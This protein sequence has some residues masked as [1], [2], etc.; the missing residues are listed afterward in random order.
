MADKHV[1]VRRLDPFCRHPVPA[2]PDENT[3]LADDDDGANEPPTLFVELARPG[4]HM[5]M[6]ESGRVVPSAMLR[7]GAE[8]SASAFVAAP[9]AAYPN[10]LDPKFT[11]L[12]LDVANEDQVLQQPLPQTPRSP[13]GAGAANGTRHDNTNNSDKRMEPANAS[14]A[15]S[16]L[17]MIDAFTYVYRCARV[18]HRP[19]VLRVDVGGG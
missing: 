14:R 19:C 5:V 8:R 7:P 4:T 3:Q 17:L 18:L 10:L 2:P 9:L 16:S 12:Y 15:S 13:T 11:K 6:L 1:V